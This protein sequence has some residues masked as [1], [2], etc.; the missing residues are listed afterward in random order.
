MNDKLLNFIPN[1]QLIFENIPDLYL[2]LSPSFK[3]VAVSDAY[4]KAT[5]TKR[6][7]ILGIGIFEVFPD[8]P[9][10][11][12]A[13]GVSN[14]Q[15]SLNRVVQNKVADTMAVQ[16][17]DIRC[18]LS[19]TGKFEE[20]YWSPINLPVLNKDNELVYIIHRVEDVTEFIRLKEQRFNQDKLTQEL[21]NK[22]EEM[23][24]EI[25]LRAQQLQEANKEL[26]KIHE[27]LEYRVQERTAELSQANTLLEKQMAELKRAESY[28]REQSALLDKTQ[29]AIIVQDLAGYVV[30]WNKGAECL[31]GWKATEA[32]GKTAED[33]LY[34]TET[35]RISANNVA[36]LVKQQ[37]EWNGEL[38]QTTKEGKEITVES[39][40]TLVLDDEGKPK[41]NLIIN[42][43]IT[44]KKIQAAQFLRTQ[45]ME[46]IGTLAGGIAHDL[47]NIL[48]PIL[49]GLY[50]L[51]KK[52]PDGQSKQ[53][54]ETLEQNAKRG[55]D[56]V[57]QVLSFA[58]GVEGEHVLVQPKHLIIDLE[59]MLKHTF[60][61][62]IAVRALLTDDLATVKGDATQLY[63]VLM[64]LCVNARDAMPQGGNLTIE[65]TNTQ[66][67]DHYAY[68]NPD[69]SVGKFV[70]I[71][72]TDTG[73]GMSPETSRKIFEP[74][75]TTKELGKGTGLGLSTS[76]AI[77][78][79]HK[80]F[81]NVYSELGKGTEF[82]LYLPIA[83]EETEHLQNNPETSETFKGQG[84]LILVID[85]EESIRN[86][87]RVILEAYGYK[88]IVA[89]DGMDA[90]ATYANNKA[91]IQLVITDM[92]MPTLD[93]HTT[94]KILRKVNVNLKIIST[95]GFMRNNTNNEDLEVNAF[96]AKPYTAEA[97]LK[98][99]YDVLRS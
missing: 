26:R 42:T 60:P 10:D 20:R 58:R 68:M 47:N 80:G 27:E 94:I 9:N 4:L 8:N 23:E 3:I 86:I 71:K 28:I 91:T 54:I 38:T 61:K 25:Y 35:Q 98:T 69:A 12:K 44:E 14:L 11:P 49:M 72:V 37:R 29:D 56:M 22:A 82:K 18:P 57:K 75:F 51:S 19:E 33:L 66:I 64:N 2:I 77:I 59:K 76:L 78:K 92:M 87:T 88:V 48:A 31:Y 32:T 73:L 81:I 34:T 67:D 99:V 30:F 6:E 74:F 40:W 63:Q 52:L 16:K 83:K 50:V 84:E 7:E 36:A 93:G 96:L 62:S 13:T 39:R 46:S 24:A 53:I 5:M 21:R 70:L 85:D 55:A 41:A 79:S 17:Y 97:L 43:D 65:T 45:R 15:A 1:F 95:S 90:I 89:T